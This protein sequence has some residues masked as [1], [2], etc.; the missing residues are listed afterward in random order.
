MRLMSFSLMSKKM[1][2][3]RV[4]LL[5][6]CSISLI[7]FLNFT[8]QLDIDKKYLKKGF[9]G[10]KNNSYEFN[11]DELQ[12]VTYNLVIEFFPI[13]NEKYKLFLTKENLKY[14]FIIFTNLINK[15]GDI[16]KSERTN[17]KNIFS[18]GRS[19]NSI[20]WNLFWFIANK[21]EKYK[22][23]LFF[24]SN[25]VFFDNIEKEIRLE[26]TYDYASLPVVLLLQRFFFFFFIAT[27]LSVLLISFMHWRNKKTNERN[28]KET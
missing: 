27:L 21:K 20:C 19:R 18:G 22:L 8:Y 5:L 11:L 13:S 26:E 10:L 2:L 6:L 3:S 9:F 1:S 28:V 4:I 24:Q 25:D 7:M 14:H 15:N 12:D 17:S 23:K 16:I